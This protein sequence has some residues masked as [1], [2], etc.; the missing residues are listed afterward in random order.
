MPAYRKLQM[1]RTA[2]FKAQGGRCFWCQ[3]PMV[4][5]GR[6]NRPEFATLDHVIPKAHGGRNTWQNL[7][8]AC[9]RC[10]STRGTKPPDEFVTQLKAA[11]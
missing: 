4:L 1:K 8:C 2:L 11:Q 5:G 3:Q 10:N 9:R 7:V 6:Q